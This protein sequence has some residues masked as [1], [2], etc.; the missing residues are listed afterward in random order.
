MIKYYAIRDRKTKTYLSKFDATEYGYDEPSE[1]SAYRAPELYASID[2]KAQIVRKNI[3]LEQ[4]EIVPVVSVNG[5]L[6]T[7]S[8]YDGF[9]PE[10]GEEWS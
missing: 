6:C 10:V 8:P 2:L 3:S 1:A 4:Y 5:V 9:P 7:G